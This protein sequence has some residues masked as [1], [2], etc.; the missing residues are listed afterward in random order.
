MRSGNE[1]N[2]LPVPYPNSPGIRA[3]LSRH[4]RRV[5]IVLYVIGFFPII[6]I[7]SFLFLVF[8][9]VVCY[10]RLP[11]RTKTT[12]AIHQNCHCFSTRFVLR[13][14]RSVYTLHTQPTYYFIVYFPLSLNSVRYFFPGFRYTRYI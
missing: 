3:S 10:R 11:I 13:T 2:G 8:F 6:I 1:I 14:P 5:I 9:F 12:N 7:Q 4:R